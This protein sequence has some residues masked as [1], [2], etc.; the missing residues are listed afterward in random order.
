MSFS[1]VRNYGAIPCS[2]VYNILDASYGV[3]LTETIVNPPGTVPP[4]SLP[5]FPPGC[6][7]GM[8][9]WGEI[10]IGGTQIR[11][12]IDCCCPIE[13]WLTCL[14]APGYHPFRICM[15]PHPACGF[16][17]TVDI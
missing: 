4:P 14:P 11:F 1:L 10:I 9:A 2:L 6:Y 5:P 17:V 15:Q 12:P 7:P 8:P 13:I 16:E 3:L